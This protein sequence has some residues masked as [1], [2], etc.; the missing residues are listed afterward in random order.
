MT[1]PITFQTIF[2][3]HPDGQLFSP[4]RVNLIGEHTDYSGGV[5]LPMAL[6][7]GINGSYRKNNAQ[8]INAYSTSFPQLGTLTI[9]FN[10]LTYQ[11]HLSFGNYLKGALHVLKEA[12]Y[13]IT[14]GF[15]ILIDSTLPKSAGLSSSAALE[16]LVLTIIRS[17][18][19]L[20]I[21]DTMLV[22]Y[23]K[24]IENDFMNVSSGIMDQYAVAFARKNHA[25]FLNTSSLVH[26]HA[27]INMDDYRLVMMNTNKDRDLENSDYNERFES[28]ARGQSV[29]TALTNKASLGDISIETFE[30]YH[31]Q[32]NDSFVQKRLQHVIHENQR[33]KDAFDALR[34]HDYQTF[35]QL[36][37]A[38]HQSLRDD[39][40]VSCDE[41]DYLVEENLTL[42]ATGARM[43]GAGFGGTMI[44]LYHI[45][46]L[47][48]SFDD[49]KRKY[50]EKFKRQLDIYTAKSSDGIL[51]KGR[52]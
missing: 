38:S 26:E 9:D 14:Q 44:A 35:G 42:G 49:L 8:C 25:L 37:Q 32:I 1:Q 13:K 48:S 46:D 6:S 22:R 7:I 34:R 51:I 5:V 33:T 12:G 15:D 45:D 2:K 16:M 47:P 52:E 40:E 27:P 28:I 4:G 20:D 3:Q 39:F 41:L 43:T 18:N 10:D 23:A 17:V 29:L 24:K 31:D 21:T 19:N 30:H 50:K 11:S 36:M